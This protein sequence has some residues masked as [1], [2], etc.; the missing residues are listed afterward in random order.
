MTTSP[1]Y[2]TLSYCWG[3]IKLF[4]LT[5]ENLA[6]LEIVIP[7]ES[8]CQTF[9]DALYITRSLGYEYIWIDSLCIFQDSI[10]Y[11][12]IESTKMC[13]VYSGSVLNLAASGAKD[14]TEGC[15]LDRDLDLLR[16]IQR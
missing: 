9:Q 13:S 12:R 10:E 11:W 8:L 15:L 7:D 6:D 4:K 3:K 16:A 1:N 14:G 2:L 5:R